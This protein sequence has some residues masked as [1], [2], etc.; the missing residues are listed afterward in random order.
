MKQI[1]NNQLH[2]FTN[3]K[4]TKTKVEVRHLDLSKEKETK[5]FS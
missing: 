1:I 4:E 3:I 2:N 5:V